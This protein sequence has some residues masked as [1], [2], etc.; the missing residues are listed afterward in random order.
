[1]F[2]IL[3]TAGVSS[4][5]PHFHCL[6]S[7]ILA[8]EWPEGSSDRIRIVARSSEALCGFPCGGCG[9]LPRLCPP[10]PCGRGPPASPGLHALLHA[11][12]DSCHVCHHFSGTPVGSS[13]TC[14][15]SLSGIVFALLHTE[16]APLSFMSPER[17]SLLT[18][19][20]RPP[21]F[22]I[23]AVCF[24]LGGSCLDL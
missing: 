10:S 4:R 5:A 7:W 23:I 21:V 2:F 6:P 13:L 22:F 9:N 16:L 1:M 12:M 18:P 8:T 24:F 17:P 3:T 14:S 11:S 19:L 20:K 15:I